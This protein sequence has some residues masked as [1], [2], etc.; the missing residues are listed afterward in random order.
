MMMNT[1]ARKLIPRQ[2]LFE[3]KEKS[4]VCLCGGRG[5]GW[6]TRRLGKVFVHLWA[7]T[8]RGRWDGSV[9]GGCRKKGRDRESFYFS[10]CKLC[11]KKQYNLLSVKCIQHDPLVM[12]YQDLQ[13]VLCIQF[14]S[15]LCIL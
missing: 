7:S 12:L 1:G 13:L 14:A 15:V 5:A 9:W 11:L 2:L 10:F 4:G 8:L 6:R 3:C